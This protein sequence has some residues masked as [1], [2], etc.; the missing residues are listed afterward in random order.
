V[1]PNIVEFGLECGSKV[2]FR[3]GS[4][5]DFEQ[6]GSARVE[7]SILQGL[8][9][10]TSWLQRVEKRLV[11]PGNPFNLEREASQEGL[12]GSKVVKSMNNANLGGKLI[13]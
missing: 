12:N 3:F 13:C 11:V 4:H 10:K 1:K 8:L 2:K 6:H 9:K 5:L 7:K